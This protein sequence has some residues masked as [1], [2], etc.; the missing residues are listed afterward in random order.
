MN[1]NNNK[2]FKIEAFFTLY[3]HNCSTIRCFTDFVTG[4]VSKHS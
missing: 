4:D 3:G 1:N 2:H